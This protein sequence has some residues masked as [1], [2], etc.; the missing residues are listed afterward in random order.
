[1]SR[2]FV[3]LAVL[4]A[5]FAV[6]SGIAVAEHGYAALW[7]LP[8]QTSGTLQLFSDLTVAMVLVTSWMIRDARQRRIRVWPF[9]ALTVATGSFGPLLYLLARERTRPARPPGE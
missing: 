1:V 6:I 8:F 3:L 9:M 4:T 2:R 5:A 7:R